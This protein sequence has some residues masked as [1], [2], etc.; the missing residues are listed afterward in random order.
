M[1]D[2]AGFAGLQNQA[3]AR[4]QAFADEI[5]VQAGDRQQRGDRGKL[6]GHAAVAEDDH[7]GLVLLDQA[8]GHDA[9]LLHRLGKAAL[10]AGDAEENGQRAHLEPRQFHPADL[11]KLLVRQHRPLELDAPAGRRLGM[12][13]IAL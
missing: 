7:I 11:G 4:A 2:L 12:Q 3:G 9:E 10:A 5:M 13:Q 1:M 6:A 8:A